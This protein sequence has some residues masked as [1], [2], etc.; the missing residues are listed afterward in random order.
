MVFA[1]NKPK[2]NCVF[3][4]K[5]FRVMFIFIT[6][7]FLRTGHMVVMWYLLLFQIHHQSYNLY[8]LVE[9]LTLTVM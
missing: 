7:I 3:Y 1:K 2:K 9:S 8:D 4:K 5:L 6:Y